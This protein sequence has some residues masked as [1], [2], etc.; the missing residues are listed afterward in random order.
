MKNLVIIGARGYG[1]EIVSLIND[2]NSREQNY[3]IKGFLDDKADALDGYMN[4]PP[5]LG[6]V[7]T[8]V[9]EKNELFVCALG[10]VAQ[11]K[12]YTEMINNKGGEFATL[13]HPTVRIHQNSVIGEGAVINF[14]TYISCDVVIGKQVHIFASCIIGHDC[15]IGDWNI[16]GT[17]VFLGGFVTLEKQ[18][19]V[20]TNATV[21]P[22]ITVGSE[23][24]VGAGSV[25]IKNVEPNTTVFGAP[26]IKIR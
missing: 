17:K 14:N 9:P 10:E 1:R 26:A 24:I 20:Y 6:P 18:V 22:K 19:Q 23:A 8:Y 21:L 15:K 7:E 11:R 5:I 3:A 12:K 25:V 2:I 16:V 13:I 4:Y